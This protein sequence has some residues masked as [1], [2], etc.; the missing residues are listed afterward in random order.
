M[1][2]WSRSMFGAAAAAALVLGGGA[3]AYADDLESTVTVDDLVVSTPVVELGVLGCET[4]RD[5]VVKLNLDR[6]GNGAATIFQSG[7]TL[8][9]SR[10]AQTNVSATQ[11]IPP[12]ITLPGDW[13][14]LDQHS[15]VDSA[16]TTST[17]T[18]AAGDTNGTFSGQASYQASGT[19]VNGDTKL[20]TAS[21]N[22]SW[23]V[24]NCGVVVDPVDETAPIV[25]LL[26]PT[27]PIPQGEEAYATWTADDEDG[28]SGVAEGY[29]SGSILLDTSTLGEHTATAPAG[30]SVDEA[31]NPSAEASCTFTV[32]DVTPP[33]V[34]LICPT[35]P[36][37]LD[38]V[39]EASWT[40]TDEAGGS[41]IADGYESGSIPLD[42]SSVGWKTATAAEGT[43]LDKAG[44]ASA[45]VSCGYRV[46]YDFDGFFRPVDMGGV[47]NS[48]KAGSAVPMKFSLGGDQ[49]LDIIADGYPKVVFTACGAAAVDAIETTV[50][51]G[52]SSLSYDA[53]TGQYVYVW[54]TQK[55]WAGTCGTFELQLDDGVTRTAKFKFLK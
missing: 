3:I 2:R 51:A 42:T 5:V 21:V 4:S 11:P 15:T 18:V 36:V 14:S 45:A 23:S 27:D 40:A 43:A 12:T 28:G 37:L 8:T 25:T 39:A 7:S 6:G 52:G 53:V 20:R 13:A 22:V 55:S 54:K 34:A 30:T 17:I 19:V 9:F 48:V 26:C 32:V 29:E 10:T 50:T 41:G 47:V 44:N 46:I 38:S 35:E 31:G 16:K 33:V 1:K 24:E 49:G